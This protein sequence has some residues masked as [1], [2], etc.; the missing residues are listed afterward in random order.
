MPENGRH[1]LQAAGGYRRERFVAG[2]AGA[3]AVLAVVFF[4]ALTDG[5]ERG[6]RPD[7]QA[8][9]VTKNLKGVPQSGITLGDPHAKVTL[10]EFADLKCPY[11][12]Q[13]SDNILPTLIRRYVRTG[14]LRMQLR[15]VAILDHFTPTQESS[16]AAAVA[17]AMT[18]QNKLW[19]FAGLFYL[20]QQDELQ[21]YVTD[22]FLRGL[23]RRV[24]GANETRAMAD[25]KNPLARNFIID[26]A[27]RF[28]AIGLPG[29]PTFIVEREGRKPTKL[30]IPGLTDP[31]AW[32]P[33]IEQLLR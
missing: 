13:F 33:V 23:V 3:L 14:K 20:N 6:E 16:A 22:D 29:T 1:D 5:G 7:R 2:A 26:G 18:L 8:E 12:K 15:V 21:P 19:N 28:S 9:Q 10:I 17:S 4:F 30:A 11:C 32:V 27:R 25:R 31:D 24:P